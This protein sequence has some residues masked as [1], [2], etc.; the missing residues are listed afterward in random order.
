MP[1]RAV[2]KGLGLILSLALVGYLFD[3]SDLGNAVNEAWV[4]A[5]IR[6]HGLEGTLL[7]L[8]MGALFTA[9]GLPRQIIAFLA[10]YAFGLAPGTLLGTLAALLGCLITFIY[11]RSFGRSL[12]RERLGKRAAR[13]DQF[14]FEHPFFM[15]LLIRLLPVGSNLL[16]NLAAGIS[17]VRMAPFLAASFVGFLPQTLVFVLVGSGITVAPT[18]RIGMATVLFLLSGMLGAY[19]YHR[20][21]H[22]L[23]IDDKVD[24][25]L[26]EAEQ[27]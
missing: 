26:G 3:S 1:L 9:V 15:T 14:I 21:R 4:D 17:S 23:G 24:A 6:G 11:A 27:S 18:L 8:A 5:H 2:I 19:L 12:L 13:F 10:G 20:H 16:T 7:F 25:A 22:G